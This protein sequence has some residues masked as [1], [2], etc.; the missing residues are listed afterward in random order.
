[1][2]IQLNSLATKGKMTY[3][4]VTVFIYLENNNVTFSQDYMEQ[5]TFQNEG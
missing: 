4:F 3:C 2:I 5:L 1:M